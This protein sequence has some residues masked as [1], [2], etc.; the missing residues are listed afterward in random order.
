MLITSMNYL[1]LGHGMIYGES[2]GGVI[3]GNI[4]SYYGYGI[5]TFSGPAFF[6]FQC[7]FACAATAI[8]SGAVS[9]RMTFSYY[10]WLVFWYFETTVSSHILV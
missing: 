2:L 9:E 5:D 10:T 6:F 4:S 3:G 7:A 1:T 8:L